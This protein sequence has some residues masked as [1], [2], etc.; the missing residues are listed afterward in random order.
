VAFPNLFILLLKDMTSRS[1]MQG[2]YPGQSHFEVRSTDHAKSQDHG[3]H[4]CSGRTLMIVRNE[5]QGRL[6]DRVS[7]RSGAELGT[8]SV[9]LL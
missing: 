1:T 5:V 4:K 7:V 3:I 2:A 6:R 9:L 8:C